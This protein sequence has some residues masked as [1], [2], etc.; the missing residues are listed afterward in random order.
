MIY[1]NFSGKRAEPK[2]LQSK[3]DIPDWERIHWN[4]PLKGEVDGERQNKKKIGTNSVSQG[5]EKESQGRER[6]KKQ[7][8]MKWNVLKNTRKGKKKGR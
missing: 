8:R 3:T 5:Y 6:K 7:G 2:D 1:R 4:I